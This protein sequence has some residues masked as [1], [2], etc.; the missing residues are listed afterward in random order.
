MRAV[1]TESSDEDYGE[2]V[3]VPKTRAQKELAK[4][5][6]KADPSPPLPTA[7]PAAAQQKQV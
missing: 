7:K 6:V 2:E 3:I 4:K 1:E 5:G